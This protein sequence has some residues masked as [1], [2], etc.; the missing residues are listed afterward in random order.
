M[1]GVNMSARSTTGT[2]RLG[3][4]GVRGRDFPDRGGP[5]SSPV[6]AEVTADGG[7]P[8]GPGS[9]AGRRS[10]GQGADLRGVRGL[11]EMVR[12][13]VLVAG[14]SPRLSGAD[15]AHVKRLAEAGGQLPPIVVHRPSMR[16][17]DGAHRVRAAVLNGAAQIEVEFFDG[18]AD[19]A[20]IRAVEL[21]IAHG[22]PLT[23]AERKLAAAR[24]MASCP[25]LS[26]RSIAGSCGLSDKTVAGI[27]RSAADGLRP[28]G[29]RGRDGRVHPVDGSAG[30]RRA[31]QALAA[32]PAASLREVARVSGVSVSTAKDVRDRLGRGESPV[33]P[34]RGTAAGAAA[35][36]GAAALPGSGADAERWAGDRVRSISTIFE[37]LQRDPSLRFTDSGRDLL[38]L[39]QLQCAALG[40]WPQLTDQLPAHCT[41]L[42]AQMA[43]QCAEEWDAAA[44]ALQKRSPSLQLL[45]PPEI[46]AA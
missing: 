33:L 21:N 6:G 39:L 38:R 28:N 7:L 46:S 43:R 11:R 32:R 40:R 42:V 31:G 29:R 13:D 44:S 22:L 8:D 2:A 45:L 5:G 20:F 1:D 36:P 17:I 14:D 19:E 35:V 10:W 34:G 23:L 27:R 30:R 4:D 37:K 25:G 41:G 12:I 9:G 18:S 24:I 16:I 26:D 15:K 3:R